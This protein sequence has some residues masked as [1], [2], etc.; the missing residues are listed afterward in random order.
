MSGAS[1]EPRSGQP[2]RFHM[3]GGLRPVHSSAVSW[4]SI[5]SSSLSTSTLALPTSASSPST[6]VRG[7]DECPFGCEHSP[8]IGVGGPLN[9]A[10]VSPGP[11]SHCGLCLPEEHRILEDDFSHSA[12][13]VARQRKHVHA[14]FCETPW[15]NFAYF[16]HEGGHGSVSGRSRPAL[17]HA[18]V[19]SMLQAT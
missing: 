13:C 2:R 15:K 9:T 18:L 6:T 4:C 14:S 19:F 8:I 1:T 11:W 5:A 3:G 16:L 12:R 7:R 10:I 17:L